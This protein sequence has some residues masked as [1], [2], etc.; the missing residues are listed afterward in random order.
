MYPKRWT[1][2]FR[3]FRFDVTAKGEEDEEE[4]ILQLT[5]KDEGTIPIER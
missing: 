2:R 1:E 3:M 4:V 5:Q